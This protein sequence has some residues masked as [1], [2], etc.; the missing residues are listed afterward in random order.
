MASGVGAAV[1]DEQNGADEADVQA[2][3]G[4]LEVLL[5][6]VHQVLADLYR[7]A[8]QLVEQSEYNRAV[9]ALI[10]HAV[11]E[12]SNNLAHYL[13]LAEGVKLPPR[14]DVTV[15][16]KGLAAQL[17]EVGSQLESLPSEETDDALTEGGDYSIRLREAVQ[18]AVAADAKAAGNAQRIRAFVAAWELSAEPTATTA[19]F[20]SAFE[21]FMSY[22]HL[23]RVAKDRTPPKAEVR[24]QFATFETIVAARLRGFFDADGSTGGNRSRPGHGLAGRAGRPLVSGV[25]SDDLRREDVVDPVG[26]EVLLGDLGVFAGRSAEYA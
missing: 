11:R 1:Q 10:S 12:I 19:M 18:E 16:M 7:H 25:R 24:E 15:A 20:G 26:E 17:H 4:D 3:Q 8:V 22:A 6:G 5:S 23:D 13:G 9:V 21:F 14:A 2:E